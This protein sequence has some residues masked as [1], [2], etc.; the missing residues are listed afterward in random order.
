MAA[1]GH[2]GM[3][4]LSRVNPCVTW[5][6]LLKTIVDRNI[7]RLQYRQTVVLI[8]YVALPAARI[9]VYCE[10][11]QKYHGSREQNSGNLEYP[12]PLE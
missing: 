11:F 8:P 2:L 10:K 12:Q 3:T 1:D 7:S 4:A 5:A 9:Q 6:F